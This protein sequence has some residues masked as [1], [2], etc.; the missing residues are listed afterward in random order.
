MCSKLFY[1]AHCSLIEQKATSDDTA[2]S[3]FCCANVELTVTIV[4]T[5]QPRARVVGQILVIISYQCFNSPT[6]LAL[7]LSIYAFP[8]GAELISLKWNSD[9]DDWLGQPGPEVTHVI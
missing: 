4:K 9:I 7:W 3:T 5:N 8:Y 2:S 6:T 1:L